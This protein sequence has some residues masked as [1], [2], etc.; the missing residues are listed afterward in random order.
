M[1]LPEPNLRFV[2]RP[3]FRRLPLFAER[4]E[5]PCRTDSEAEMRSAS[6]PPGSTMVTGGNCGTSW[7]HQAATPPSSRAQQDF[8]IAGFGDSN[9]NALPKTAGWSAFLDSR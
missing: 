9:T 1:V 3:A 5:A 6:P 8:Q 7:S 2:V 4:P